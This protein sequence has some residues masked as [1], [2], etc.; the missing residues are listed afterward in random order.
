MTKKEELL[1]D[2]CKL[3]KMSLEPTLVVMAAL[4]T[5][6]QQGVMLV[7]FTSITRRIH[8]RTKYCR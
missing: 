8:R 5:D 4:R 1:I 6:K 3:L 2:G 7:G